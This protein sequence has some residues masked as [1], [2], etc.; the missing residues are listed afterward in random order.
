[1]NFLYTGAQI[2]NVPQSNPD[3]S[4]GGFISN[5]PVP[6]DLSGNL[7]NDISLLGQERGYSETKAIV[8]KNETGGDVTDVYLYHNYPAND[9]ITLEWAPV[10]V[11][12]GKKMEA[13]SVIRSSPVVGVFSEPDGVGNKILLANSLLDNGVI[14]LW[15]RR[16]IDSPNPVNSVDAEDLEAYLAAL[17]KEERIEIVVEWT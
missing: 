11:P 17:D 16:T 6:N 2:F 15:I 9:I 1:M 14:G 4:L 8:L 10:T 13:I 5:S 3:E 7:F 12:D